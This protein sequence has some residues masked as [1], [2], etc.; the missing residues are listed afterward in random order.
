MCGDTQTENRTCSMY[1]IGYND[2]M[3]GVQELPPGCTDA[4][5]QQYRQGVRDARLSR[6]HSK[7]GTDL[8]EVGQPNR[9][10]IVQ[11]G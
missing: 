1:S 4:D 11:K 7:P 5:I 3:D 8:A 2:E 9:S 6:P 10:N